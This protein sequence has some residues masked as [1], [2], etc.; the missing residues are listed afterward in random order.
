MWLILIH[1]GPSY[2]VKHWAADAWTELVKQFQKNGWRQIA[3]LGARVGSYS[4][5]AA[6]CFQAVPGTV[7]LI[8]ELSLAETVALIAQANLTVSVFEL[9]PLFLRRREISWQ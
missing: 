9:S 2:P 1:A 6:D 7:S 4:G 5:A 8:N 3:Q